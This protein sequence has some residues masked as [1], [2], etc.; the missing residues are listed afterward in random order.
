M[1]ASSDEAR[2]RPSLNR[3]IGAGLLGLTALAICMQ[4][5]SLQPIGSRLGVSVPTDGAPSSVAGAQR[6][7]PTELQAIV[8]VA[9]CIARPGLYALPP[10]GG[11]SVGRLIAAA[12]GPRVGL[13][14][15]A[16]IV[17]RVDAS[18]RVA[19]WKDA[20]GAIDSWGGGRC[21]VVQPAREGGNSGKDPIVLGGDL[22]I[23]DDA[24]NQEAW[25]STPEWDPLTAE[26]IGTMPR[27]EIL[28]LLVQ[29]ARW[30]H[31]MGLDESLSARLRCEFDLL[32]TALQRTQ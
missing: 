15:R 6:S 17:P 2:D 10:E 14:Y 12:G 28:D 13:Q 20:G 21:L 25:P 9:G 23:V 4:V 16:R 22:L 11:L 32:V 18:A 31:R 19:A 1:R 24:P 8:G 7:E 3:A 27:Q 30:R 26:R 29:V 5:S